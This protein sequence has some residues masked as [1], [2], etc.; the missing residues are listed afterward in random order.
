MSGTYVAENKEWPLN[1]SLIDSQGMHS[2]TQYASDTTFS[3][4]AGL[5]VMNYVYYW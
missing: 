1:F 2:T 5:P 4:C 3:V